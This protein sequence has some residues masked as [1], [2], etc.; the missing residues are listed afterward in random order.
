MFTA[1]V[2]SPQ[3]SWIAA[4]LGMRA[5]GALSVLVF[6]K[7][8]RIGLPVQV[9]SSLLLFATSGNSFVCSSDSCVPVQSDVGIGKIV[10]MMEQDCMQI[11]NSLLSIHT[12]WKV[13]L[14]MAVGM[15]FLYDLV[16]TAAFGA[17]GV[18]ILVNAI[19]SI[20]V[21]FLFKGFYAIKKITDSRIKVRRSFILFASFVCT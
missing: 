1:I 8:M 11:A 9:R 14:L 12:I 17:L 16:G 3:T 20:V 10:N 15:T 21:P 7:A 19:Q 2:V 13:P 18:M 4:R 5:R 6:N